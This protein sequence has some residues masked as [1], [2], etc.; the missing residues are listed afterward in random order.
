MKRKFLTIL[1][2]GLVST[3][4]AMPTETFAASN[5]G[6]AKQSV[7]RAGAKKPQNPPRRNVYQTNNRPNNA[8]NRP[9]NRPNNNRPNNRPGNNKVVAGNTVVVNH[10]VDRN[11]HGSYY[12]DYHHGH[13]DD[14]D[15]DFFDTLGTAVAVTAGVGLTAAVIGEI[16][17]DE[18][19]DCQQSVHYGQTY[20][21]C[22]GVWYQ[23]TMAG[24]N[25]QYVVVEAPR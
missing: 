10:G 14:H 9:N 16:F 21:Y 25:M 23:P 15:D 19:D 13:W 20:L 1:L 12:N 18:P 7:N 17:E 8:G 11:Y 2:A 4:L 24:T 3:S 22:N 6:Q 5:R